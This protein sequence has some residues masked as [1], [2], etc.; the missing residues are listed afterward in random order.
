MKKEE[1]NKV[2][3]RTLIDHLKLVV[4]D[5][6]SQL[7]LMLQHI[8][9]KKI[10]EEEF[11]FKKE[12]LEIK[13]IKNI[14][15]FERNISKAIGRHYAQNNILMRIKYYSKKEKIIRSLLY[16]TLANAKRD[17]MDEGIVI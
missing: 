14:K 13:N 4:E 12:L 2:I 7:V 16:K 9:Y 6:V 17:L 5:D 15:K 11:D 10:M 1:K 3:E 8:I